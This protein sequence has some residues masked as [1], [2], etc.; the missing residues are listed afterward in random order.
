MFYAILH[1]DS[2]Y[3][4]GD[5]Y[6]KLLSLPT[7]GEW[8]EIPGNCRE[9]KGQGLS[10]RGESGLKYLGIA[11]K[12]KDKGSLPTRGEWIEMTIW[13]CCA[14]NITS[15]PTRGEWIEIAVKYKG[16]FGR[17]GLSPRGESGLKFVGDGSTA[18]FKG[19]SPRG[20]SGLK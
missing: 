15:L 19:L 11:E 14:S 7:R 17:R 16:R 6:A 4:T 2:C 20:E 9:T 8:I 18:K 1:K 12:P 5:F 3:K 10:P 13:K